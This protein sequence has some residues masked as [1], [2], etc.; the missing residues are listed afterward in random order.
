MLVIDATAVAPSLMASL[1]D[2][3]V[4]VDDPGRDEVPAPS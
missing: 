1:R 4:R 2:V 3:G